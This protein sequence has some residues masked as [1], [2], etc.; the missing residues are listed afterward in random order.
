[1]HKGDPITQLQ[2]VMSDRLGAIA[3]VP[4]FPAKFERFA[5]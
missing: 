5:T 4:R 3:P 1:M 2:D